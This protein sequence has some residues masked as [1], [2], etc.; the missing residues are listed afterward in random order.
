MDLFYRNGFHAVGLDQILAEA[1]LTK[2]TFYNHF[3]SK[4]ELIVAV[5][6]RRDEIESADWWRAVEESAPQ[7]PRRQLD[8]VFEVL[9]RWFNDEEFRGCIFINAAAEFP[10]PHDPAHQ[11]AAAHKHTFAA[12]VRRRA[13]A[14]GLHDVDAFTA[15]Y[16]L[17]VEGAIT[18][19]LV[20]DDGDAARVARR[21][22]V[23]LIEQHTNHDCS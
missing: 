14:A 4:D 10:L 13:V 9:H 15:A 23:L 18:V 5:I 1:R 12:H 20:T 17:L 6:E 21:M 8:A 11:A 19:R 3:E 7:D 16:M 2:T 22:A